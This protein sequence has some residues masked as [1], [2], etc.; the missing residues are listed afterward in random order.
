[1]APAWEMERIPAPVA[2]L[3]AARS[4]IVVKKRRAGAERR[5]ISPWRSPNRAL[6]VNDSHL[7]ALVSPLMQR[8]PTGWLDITDVRT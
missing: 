1:M 4:P 2:E 3:L 6:Q 5:E 7:C 8:G